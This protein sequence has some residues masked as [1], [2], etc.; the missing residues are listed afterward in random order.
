MAFEQRKVSLALR[1]KGSGFR[2]YPGRIMTGT[3]NPKPETYSCRKSLQLY[4]EKLLGRK[5]TKHQCDAR[6]V[7]NP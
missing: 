6:E 7:A 2:L 3:L 5:A 4:G 1:V